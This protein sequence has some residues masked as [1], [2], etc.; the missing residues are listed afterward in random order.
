MENEV[1][2]GVSIYLTTSLLKMKHC[3][4]MFWVPGEGLTYI[5]P[6]V[7]AR[8]KRNEGGTSLWLWITLSIYR[9]IFFQW[10][11]QTKQDI[12]LYKTRPSHHIHTWY[13]ND[14]YLKDVASVSAPLT[15]K[16]PTSNVQ[17]RCQ[18]SWEAKSDPP[19]IRAAANI[20][21]ST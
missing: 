13:I 21:N 6:F 15:T 1:F 20:T 5:H 7:V 12:Q 19:P 16:Q 2:P 3:Q 18:P 8:G 4:E 17:H 11:K 10:N 14:L 9:R